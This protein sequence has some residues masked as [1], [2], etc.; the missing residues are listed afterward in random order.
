MVTLALNILTTTYLN[1]DDFI[2]HSLLSYAKIEKIPGG[3]VEESRVLSGVMINKDVTHP[4]MRR[5]IERPRIVLLDCPL[6]YKKGESQTNIEI[7]GEQVDILFSQP[8]V[9]YC[10]LSV[11]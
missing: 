4:K 9:S 10:C 8:I 2:P 5:Y 7:L 6:E 11:F 1:N 3:S